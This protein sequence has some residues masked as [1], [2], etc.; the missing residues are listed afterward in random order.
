M[1]NFSKQEKFSYAYV[2]GKYAKIITQ[3]TGAGVLADPLAWSYAE[4]HSYVKVDPASVGVDV[5]SGV[6]DVY[7][8]VVFNVGAGGGSSATDPS[9]VVITRVGQLINDK[10][11]VTSG[12]LQGKISQI[13][14]SSLPNDAGF[15]TSSSI[16]IPSAVSQLENDSGFV[17]YDD[18]AY[19]Q[20]LETISEL[21]FTVGDH[22]SSLL[23]LENSKADRQELEAVSGRIPS[24]V[25]QLDNDAGYAKSDEV[26]SLVRYIDDLSSS[27][28]EAYSLV[29]KLREDLDASREEIAKQAAVIDRQASQIWVNSLALGTGEEYSSGQD[30]DDE[31][32]VITGA[33]RTDDQPVI[34]Y[35]TVSTDGEDAPQVTITSI[36]A[37]EDSPREDEST[38]V[39]LGSRSIAQTAV[40][41]DDRSAEDI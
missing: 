20:S 22:S 40:T 41:Y 29:Y 31:E 24:A 15:I 9:G 4:T 23:S 3:A 34:D 13:T 26:S 11:Y 19:L 37:V 5:P 25:S 36:P 38:A 18:S 32:L 10:H 14:L 30:R 7:A 35:G 1:D 6:E 21:S 39:P 17:S 2:D 16:A 27:L 12:E 33:G 8:K 28:S